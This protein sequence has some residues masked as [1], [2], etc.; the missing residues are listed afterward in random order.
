[1]P[2]PASCPSTKKIYYL[3]KLQIYGWRIIVCDSKA[4]PTTDI[5]ICWNPTSSPTLEVGGLI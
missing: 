4:L 3:W 5:E 2:S 1:M